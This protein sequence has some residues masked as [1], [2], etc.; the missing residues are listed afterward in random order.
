MKSLLCLV[1]VLSYAY[2]WRIN[3]PIYS[4]KVCPLQKKSYLEVSKMCTLFWAWLWQPVRLKTQPRIKITCF[5]PLIGFDKKSKKKM[6]CG[7]KN[8]ISAKKK[9]KLLLII[10][11]RF[12]HA[13]QIFVLYWLNYELCLKFVLVI[14]LC[15]LNTGNTRMKNIDSAQNSILNWGKI[16]SRC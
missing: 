3:K 1:Y 16:H 7:L 15:Y 2:D 6:V 9:N 14:I 12:Y 10:C 8:S 13:Y 4:I 5:Q 11:K